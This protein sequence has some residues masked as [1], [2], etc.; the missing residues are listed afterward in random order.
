MHTGA[1]VQTVTT[2]SDCIE[3]G[4]STGESV[5]ASLVIAADGARSK[6]R[7]L[8]SLR[9]LCRDYGQRAIV[10]HVRSELPHHRTAWQRFLPGGPLA[11]LPLADGRSSVVWSL[12][13]EAAQ[14][15][16]EAGEAAFIAALQA[17]SGDTLGKLSLTAARAVLPL[18]AQHAPRYCAPRIALVGDAAHAVHPLAGQGANLGLLDAA[19]LAALV[20]R[21][22]EQGQDPGDLRVLQRYERNRKGENLGMLLA[23]D[24]IDRVFRLPAAVGP[25]RRAGIGIVDR[26]PFVK[27]ELMSRALGTKVAAEL[28]SAA[29]AQYRPPAI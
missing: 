28:A 21:A 22:V 18:R 26:L 3:V 8:A 25:A 2:R 17:A 16:A 15:L 10:T 14:G 4:L 9:V 19:A 24:A 29:A 11:F 1:T 5:S 20:E 6:L 12:P 7:E 27:R 23:L 13:N